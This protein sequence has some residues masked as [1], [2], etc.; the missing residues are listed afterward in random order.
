MI[1]TWEPFE[2]KDNESLAYIIV[3]HHALVA[4]HYY[5]AR[6]YQGVSFTYC[7]SLAHSYK[8]NGEDIYNCVAQ[9]QN[10]A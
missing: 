2:K 10:D 9:G 6:R 4:C 8:K 7:G 5:S 1:W 3:C